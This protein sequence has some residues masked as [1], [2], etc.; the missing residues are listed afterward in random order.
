[1]SPQIITSE[2][3]SKIV[4]GWFGLLLLFFT[5]ITLIFNYHWKQYGISQKTLKRLRKIYFSVSGVLL[6][7]AT[8]LFF[9][10]ILK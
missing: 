9:I 6:I 2:L 8:V 10:Y 1:M 7:L 4:A 3:V 5:V